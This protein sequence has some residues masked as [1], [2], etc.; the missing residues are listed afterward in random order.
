[1]GMPALDVLLTRGARLDE[2]TLREMWS[3]RAEVMTLRSGV[4][5]REDFRW[6]AGLCRRANQV[7]LM[8]DR[9]ARLRG[10]SVWIYAL[11]TWAGRRFLDLQP[12]YWMIHPS[13]RGHPAASR[14]GARL[15]LRLL[16]ASR[17]RPIV[18][19]NAAYLQSYVRLAPLVD[20]WT[21]GDPAIP[22]W[23]RGF[24]VHAMGER[25]PGWDAADPLVEMPTRPPPLSERWLAAHGRE[26]AFVDYTRENPRWREGYALPAIAVTSSRLLAPLLR[27]LVRRA[28]RRLLSR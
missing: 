21:V 17:G 26:Q 15:G 1:M 12:E 25:F 19:V 20:F 18:A 6:F 14:A 8:R 27:E 9:A 11:R 5:E 3:L 24:L 2:P 4:D 16:V 7:L 22:R 13:W 10:M 28:R 23:E